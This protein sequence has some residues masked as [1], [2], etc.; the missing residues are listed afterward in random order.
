MGYT[1]YWTFKKPALKK[2]NAEKAEKTW[3]KALIEC[4]KIVKS[5]YSVH[6]GISGFSA[7]T[8]NLAN[9]VVFS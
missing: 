7:H 5:Y 6:G 2:D 4:Q 3:K 9:M 1:H 8:Q